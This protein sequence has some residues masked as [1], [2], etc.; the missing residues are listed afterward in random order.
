[1]VS[2]KSLIKR[3]NTAICCK[4]EKEADEL[5]AQLKN[6]GY[7]WH[8]MSSNTNWCKSGTCYNI[9]HSTMGYANSGWHKDSGYDIYNF[10]ELDVMSP[11]QTDLDCIEQKLIKHGDIAKEIVELNKEKKRLKALIAH[12]D[13]S[14]YLELRKKFQGD[15]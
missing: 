2:L 6:Y 3:P 5:L 1:M 11:L 12:K 15:K 14:K 7:G 4:T 13:Y 9:S 8:D 10:N